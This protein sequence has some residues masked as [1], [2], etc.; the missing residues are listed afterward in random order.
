MTE[1][2]LKSLDGSR[3]E[4]R[5]LRILPA[6][7]DDSILQCELSTVSLRDE[8]PEY[9]ALS[10]VWGDPSVTE[11]IYINGSVVPVTKNVASAM[12]Q[13]RKG[14][15]AKE[16]ASL[17]WADAI[18]IDQSNTE[19]KTHQVRI[20][21][22]IYERAAC[23]MSWLSPPCG[24][25]YGAMDSIR[26]LYATVLGSRRDEWKSRSWMSLFPE[27][28]ADEAMPNG[29]QGN[30]VWS[31]I[32]MLMRNSYWS[33]SW[34]VQEMAYARVNFFQVGEQSLTFDELYEFWHW[35]EELKQWGLY[36]QSEDSPIGP[37]T[38]A[39]ISKIDMKTMRLVSAANGNFRIGAIVVTPTDFIVACFPLTLKLQA[40]DPRDKLFALYSLGLSAVRPDYSKD[41]R[42]VYFEFAGASVESYG[43]PDILEF[44]GL[45]L[46]EN[47]QLP[48]WVPD[49]QALS[50]ISPETPILQALGH[51][52]TLRHSQRK[53][54]YGKMSEKA[55]ARVVD[56]MGSLVV[57]GLKCGQVAEVA[58]SSAWLPVDFLDYFHKENRIPGSKDLTRPL[59]YQQGLSDVQILLRTI[60]M[61]INPIEN[62]SPHQI[63]SAANFTRTV[64]ALRAF[65]GNELSELN[66]SIDFKRLYGFDPRTP[67]A[68]FVYDHLL[69][70]LDR[71]DLQTYQAIGV[72]S[73]GS[74][75]SGTP[76]DK[77][78]A[79]AI[80]SHV[81]NIVKS[82]FC[83]RTADGDIGLGPPQVRVGDKICVLSKCSFPVILRQI[84]NI[85]RYVGPCFMVGLM[86]GEAA[87]ALEAEGVEAP[88]KFDIR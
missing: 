40:T 27:F 25:L 44:A 80:S 39:T 54:A 53:W 46:A 4:I 81:E 59:R 84:G 68:G 52:T 33:R 14:C 1:P 88:V 47:L 78:N 82:T 6:A 16:Y 62:V 87:R 57:C 28:W 58:H 51:F 12:R 71:E 70:D 10:Y 38:S 29:S 2:I 15:P 63:L 11:N 61:D 31:E 7:S 36:Y 37:A 43:S 24:D 41:A 8:R 13:F 77:N 45:G 55:R 48:S 21:P 85:Y 73:W 64:D 86:E 26:R 23:V 69:S 60:F 3:S 18:C 5:L 32:D 83:F 30:R 49:W 67:F 74:L 79:T 56:G 9:A 17:L 50:R 76:L 75:E 65:F 72:S 35:W 19:E 20:M 22:I 66:N 42:Q 34:I